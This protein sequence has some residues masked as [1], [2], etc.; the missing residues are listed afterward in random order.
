MDES[1][2]SRPSGIPRPSRIPVPRT[3]PLRISPS[4]ESLTTDVAAVGSLRSPKLRSTPSRDQLVPTCH[5]AQPSTASLRAVSSPPIRPVIPDPDAPLPSRSGRGG[6]APSA[7]QVFWSGSTS[8]SL[9]RRASQ[10]W[11]SAAAMP[12]EE[13]LPEEHWDAVA[14][15]FGEEPAPTAASRQRLSLAERTMETLSRLPSSPSVKGRAAPSFYDPPPTAIHFAPCSGSCR[16]FDRSASRSRASSRPG[17]ISGVDDSISTFRSQMAAASESVP[18]I[19]EGTP[20]R[21]RRSIASFQTPARPPAARSARTAAHSLQAHNPLSAPC[22]RA[23]SPE[24][25]VSDFAAPR[26]ASRAPAPRAAQRSSVCGLSTKASMPALRKAAATETTRKASLA[27]RGSSATSSEGAY[28]STASVASA[29]T[30][31]TS[32]SADAGQ[33]YKK[34]SAAL[35]EQIARARAAKRAQQQGAAANPAPGPD[36]VPLVPT[37]ASFDFGLSD[38][39]FNQR[40]DDKSQAKALKSRL[41]TARTTGRLNIAAMG[42]KE[43]PPEVLNMYNLDSI[44]EFGGSWAESVDLTRFVAADNELEM[45]SDSVFPDVD[46][47]ELA[48]DEDSQGNIFA[49]LETLDLHGNILVNL[50]MGL[51]RLSLLTSLNLVCARV[52]LRRYLYPASG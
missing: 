11:I 25:Y 13:A 37:D 51:R 20:L 42:L 50:P 3:N 26:P 27:S 32:D 46:P 9:R 16:Q 40:R 18:P 24:R 36:D 22:T 19:I 12:E 17:S 29:N 2:Q 21:S 47:Q 23:P 45:I 10:Q 49:G 4:R 38:D 33:A 39:P 52:P 30:A 34:T 31:I 8:G 7:S 15:D 5:H 43:I 41:E 6:A 48:D 1:R 35:R 44:A 28:A 14:E